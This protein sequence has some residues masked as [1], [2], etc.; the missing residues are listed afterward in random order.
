MTDFINYLQCL[1]EEE[2]ALLTAI[3]VAIGAALR[4]FEKRKSKEKQGNK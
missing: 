2:T 3:V 1:D 4:Y